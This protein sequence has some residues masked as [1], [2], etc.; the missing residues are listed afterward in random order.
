[1]SKSELKLCLSDFS[2]SDKSEYD[3]KSGKSDSSGKESALEDIIG[4]ED[5]VGSENL[6]WNEIYGD[7]S[8]LKL[9]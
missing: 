7:F 9:K 5:E 3:E 4:S 2:Y 6:W 1:M 8:N